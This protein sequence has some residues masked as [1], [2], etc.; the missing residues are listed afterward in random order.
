M[1]II[2]PLRRAQMSQAFTYIAIVLLIGLIA[3]LGFKGI[4]NIMKSSCEQDKIVF[5]NNMMQ[6]VEDYSD[7]G[8]VYE[9]TIKAPC[10]ISELC[11][12]NT[13]LLGYAI[14]WGGEDIG[15]DVIY[16]GVKSNKSNIFVKGEFT[17]V[18]GRSAKVNVESG[19][20]CM[21]SRNGYFKL[22]FTGTGKNT[23]IESGWSS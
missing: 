1:D 22:V 2:I 14:G 7:R 23:R 6:F 17:E 9:E 18:I 8:S 16:S 20:L 10:D 11:F 4:S 13:S 19:I 5:V 21:K 15:D 12:V 3:V